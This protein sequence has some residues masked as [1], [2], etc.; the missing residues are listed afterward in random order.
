MLFA[1]APNIREVIA[2]PKTQTGSD[3]MAHA[4]SEAEPSQL[5]ELAIMLAPRK[6]QESQESTE[7]P[8][9]PQASS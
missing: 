4:P 7:A 3:I 9:A 8:E 5:D 6:P 1:S 2:F